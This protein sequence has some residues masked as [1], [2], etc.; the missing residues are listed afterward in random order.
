MMSQLL[1]DEPMCLRHF[2]RLWKHE[3]GNE[4]N[5]ASSVDKYHVLSWKTPVEW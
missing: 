2:V 1:M 4:M 5:Y 3:P